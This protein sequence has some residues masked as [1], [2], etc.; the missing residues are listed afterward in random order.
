MSFARRNVDARVD[1]VKDVFYFILCFAAF[2]NRLYKRHYVGVGV[3]FKV[4][5]RID[6]VGRLHLQRKIVQHLSECGK[7]KY[8]VFSD[9]EFKFE[10]QP[11]TYPQIKV[12]FAVFVG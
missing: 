6:A 2:F 4:E 3:D 12:E 7:V 10:F 1:C 11:D 8:A 5:F 9:V